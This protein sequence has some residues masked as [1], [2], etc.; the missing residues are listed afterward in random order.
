MTTGGE[1]KNPCVGFFGDEKR[2]S[3]IGF[4]GI[5]GELLWI[6]GECLRCLHLASVFVGDF[7]A[8]TILWDSSP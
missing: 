2:G 4:L 5:L 1:K 8:D 3:V 6:F 7:L